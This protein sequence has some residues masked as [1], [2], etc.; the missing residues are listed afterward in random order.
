MLM[1]IFLKLILSERETAYVGRLNKVACLSSEPE[2]PSLPL[3]SWHA[4]IHPEVIAVS[5]RNCPTI[6][7]LGYSV[8]IH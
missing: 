4:N 1:L 3:P 7:L 2:I 8:A 5:G 6:L